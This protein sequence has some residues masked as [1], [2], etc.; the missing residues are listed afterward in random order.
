MFWADR[1]A[2]EIISS[3]KYKSYWV[4]D[5]KTPSGRVHVGSLRG[6][7]I[8]DLLYKAILEQGKT[9]TYTYCINDMDPMD[10]F[11]VY[12]DR[13]KFYKYMGW[14]LFKIPSPEKGVTS[15][16]RY[17]AKE[18]IY[19]FNKIGCFPK[20]IWTSDLYAK[21]KFDN[22]IKICLNNTDK[23]RQLFEKQYKNFK[24]KDYFP[25]QPICPNCGKISTTKIYKWDGK[26]V[27]FECRENNVVYTKGCGFKGRVIPEKQNGKM[28]WKIE[29]SAHW[30]TLSINIEWSGKDHMT[31][32]GSHEIAAKISEAIF[33][34]PTP[35]AKSYEHLL[36]D[37]KKMSSSK[38][39]GAS[40]KEV[41]EILPPELLR[42]LM[43]RVHYNQTIDFDPM[44]DTIPGLFDEYDRCAKAYFESGDELLSR[45]FV[46]SQVDS[47]PKKHLYL[48]RFRTI[49]SYLQQPGTAVLTR[50][51]EDKGEDLT[52]DEKR[53]VDERIHFAKLWLT[54]FAPPDFKIE[55]R[56]DIPEEAKKLT[57]P[58]KKYLLD[59]AKIIGSSVKA[60]VLQQNLYTLAKKHKISPPQ[61]FCAIYLSLLGRTAGPKASPFLL[62][63]DKSLVVKRFTEIGKL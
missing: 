8:H 12:L 56:D 41:S 47:L 4:D 24:E 22:L 2:K 48:P 35:H 18:F 16:S 13:E 34:Y 43:V 26:Y 62:S 61:A 14:P 57:P 20:I 50:L 46:L 27:Y 11:P 23:I 55:V 63:L 9:V 49:I 38:G 37:G 53:I 32:G 28:P 52:P 44:G 3:K 30:K 29:W 59:L 60:E 42:F 19:V 51:K 36:I 21:G 40:A 39:I 1:I 25:Y 17:F 58:Q 5:M 10:G 15:F 33:H 54:K 31:Q 6:V 7:V 45:I